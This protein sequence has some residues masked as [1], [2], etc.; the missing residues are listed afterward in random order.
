MI[1]T[2]PCE[3]IQF[4]KLIS[5]ETHFTQDFI[6]S[7]TSLIFI[8][9]YA[10]YTT[11]EKNMINNLP[12]LNYFFFL[13]LFFSGSD[14][15]VDIFS[16]EQFGFHDIFRISYWRLVIFKHIMFSFNWRSM[17]IYQVKY[18]Y[19][20]KVWTNKII[21]IIS[22]KNRVPKAKTFLFNYFCFCISQKLY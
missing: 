15:T 9:L 13:W 14:W 10:P 22:V 3:L 21:I 17:D 18:I 19:I 7:W 20:C 5:F 11:R 6:Y 1:L 4:F 2:M 16:F 8:I 12:F